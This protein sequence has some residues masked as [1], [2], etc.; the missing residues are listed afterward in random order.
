MDPDLR[1]LDGQLGAG[2]LR[3]DENTKGWN[4]KESPSEGTR[5]HNR[6]ENSYRDLEQFGSPPNFNLS[7]PYRLGVG[8]ESACG[9]CDC[10][11]D[12]VID[13]SPES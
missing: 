12:T 13:R 3:A 1:F 7:V 5:H 10:M 8:G 6:R 11:I 9:Q 4:N 2:V